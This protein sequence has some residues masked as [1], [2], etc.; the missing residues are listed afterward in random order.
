MVSDEI[1]IWN[2]FVFPRQRKIS[3]CNYFLFPI[4]S[5]VQ[6]RRQSDLPQL[7]QMEVENFLEVSQDRQVWKS[8][9]LERQRI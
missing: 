2:D 1:I 8:H 4:Y 9:P 5:H 6:V 7:L 3:R